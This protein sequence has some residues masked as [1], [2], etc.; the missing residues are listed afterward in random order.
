MTKH[1]RFENAHAYFACPNCGQE[2][3]LVENSLCC[4]NRHT[5]DIAKQGYV[6]LAPHAKP[7]ANYHKSSF[8]HRQ[9]F[10]ENGYYDHILQAVAGI[11]QE[12]GWESVLDIGCGEGFYSRK[13]AEQ[14]SADLLAFDL[15]KESILLAAKSDKTKS[16]KWFVGDLTKLPIQNHSIDGILDIFS[17]AHYQEFS[18]VLKADGTLVKVVPGPNHLK[19]LRYLA[20]DQLRNETYDNNEI[21]DHFKSFD[22]NGREVLVSSTMPINLQ[23]AQTLADMTPLFFQVNQSKLDLSQLEEITIEGLILVG[24]QR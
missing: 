2:L 16:V 22:A 18:R 23:D 14:S 10:L 1:K 21:V 5:F 15:S 20:K 13:I 8:E 12:E 11:M 6:N 7:S 19:E 17:P 9:A 4:P 24:K 3:G